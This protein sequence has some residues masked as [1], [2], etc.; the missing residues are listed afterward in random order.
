VAPRAVTFAWSPDGRRLAYVAPR[1]DVYVVDADGTHRGRITRS[2]ES[3][4]AV[5]WA[6]D[7]RHLVVE[8][9]FRLF[10]IGADGR[11]E[12]LLTAGT[13]PAWS[14]KRGKIAFFRKL[15]GSE[16][17]YVNVQQGEVEVTNPENGAVPEIFSIVPG[18]DGGVQVVRQ[19]FS[20]LS[21]EAALLTDQEVSALADVAQ[22]VHAHFAPLYDG[23][24]GSFALDLEL[25]FHGPDRKL[26]IKQARP[27]VTRE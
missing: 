11:N 5:D 6:P 3:E 4:R 26:L 16:G 21:P 9:G 8:R 18:P 2:R 15:A 25:K 10:V 7:G 13:S 23:A 19:R 17:L 12:R 20:S 22:R 1:G 27:Y 24:S 14:P